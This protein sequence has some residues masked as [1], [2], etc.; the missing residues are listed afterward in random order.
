MHF[1]RKSRDCWFVFQCSSN[2]HQDQPVL[3]WMSKRCAHVFPPISRRSVRVPSILYASDFWPAVIQHSLSIYGVRTTIYCGTSFRKWRQPKTTKQQ[4]RLPPPVMQ[5]GNR[6]HGAQ[7]QTNSHDSNSLWAMQWVSVSRASAW[8]NKVFVQG[9]VWVVH[10]W[11]RYGVV[12]FRERTRKSGDRIS[13]LSEKQC[14][15]RENVCGFG[16]K[17]WAK[18]LIDRVSRVFRYTFHYWA[19]LGTVYF[20]L[21]SVNI[22]Q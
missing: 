14:E 17:T 11:L 13:G 19:P 9:K 21:L 3:V 2:A 1:P 10:M 22:L 15:L 6:V 8:A 12:D 18:W 16:V 20:S 4:P 7:M 5:S